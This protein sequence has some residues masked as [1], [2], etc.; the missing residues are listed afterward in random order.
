MYRV[1]MVSWITFVPYLYNQYE[2]HTGKL[3]IQRCFQ[4]HGFGGQSMQGKRK[5][6]KA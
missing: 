4:Q 6:N 5:A 1:I 2:I 3:A